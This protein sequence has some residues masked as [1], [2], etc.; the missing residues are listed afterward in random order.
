MSVSAYFW[1]AALMVLGLVAILVA[2][3]PFIPH[4]PALVVAA[5][6]GILVLMGAVVFCNEICYAATGRSLFG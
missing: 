4:N 5:L 6:G 1:G 3:G 2:V